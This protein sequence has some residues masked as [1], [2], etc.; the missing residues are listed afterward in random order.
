MIE[1]IGQIKMTYIIKNNRDF[2]ET[3]IRMSELIDIIENLEVGEV[4][5][6]KLK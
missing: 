6:V 2:K 1:H 5:E 3:E 4:I